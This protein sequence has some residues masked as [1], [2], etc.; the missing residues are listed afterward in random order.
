MSPAA[1]VRAVNRLYPGNSKVT[2][3]GKRKK[4]KKQ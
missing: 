1:R 4:T 3:H 2:V